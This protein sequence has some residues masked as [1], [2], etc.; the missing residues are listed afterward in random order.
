MRTSRDQQ[1]LSYPL[2]L[3][4]E[5]QPDALRLLDVS[6]EV[7]DAVITSLWDRLDEFGQTAFLYGKRVG[8]TVAADGSPEPLA[9]CRK[10]LREWLAQCCKA[11][12]LLCHRNYASLV[13]LTEES[14]R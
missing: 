3:P 11:S 12:F 1:S 13:W 9:S 8:A 14:C 10:D 7:I 5:A 6:R 2:R 4:D